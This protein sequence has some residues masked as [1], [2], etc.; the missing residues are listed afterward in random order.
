[1]PD[2]GPRE[3]VRAM[4]ETERAT[5]TLRAG[6]LQ[7]ALRPFMPEERELVEA[8]VSALLN[9]FRSM[10]QTGEEVNAVVAI[11]VCVLEEFPLWAIGKGCLQI[12]RGRAGL[13]PRYPPNDTQICNIIDRILHPYRQKLQMLQ[14][15][16]AAP[17]EPPAI[18]AE[19]QARV[20]AKVEEVRKMFGQGLRKERGA[21]L[22]MGDGRHF[23][24]IR[25]DLEARHARN[26][27]A[28]ANDAGVP[29]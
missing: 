27:A 14:N 9:G 11:T 15:L 10:R 20:D 12:A 4:T 3:I 22:R 13:D 2:F 5:I 29:E 6:E 1:V 24:R 7:D 21:P 17:V 28:A 16:L 25:A 26:D 23:E 18:G 19:E 8:A